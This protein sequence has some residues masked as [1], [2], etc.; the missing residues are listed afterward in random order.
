MRAE[1][2]KRSLPKLLKRY[3][4]VAAAI[5]RRPTRR[6]RKVSHRAVLDEWL[7]TRSY[8][9][10][11]RAFGLVK[12]GVSFIIGRAIRLAERMDQSEAMNVKRAPKATNRESNQ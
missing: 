11:A 10:T 9:Q 5:D 4:E 12:S 3:D 6:Q 7:V 1:D 2:V 8:A